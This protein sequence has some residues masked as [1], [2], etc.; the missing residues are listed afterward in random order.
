V[1]SRLNQRHAFSTG[2]VATSILF[3]GCS[4]DLLASLGNAGAGAPTPLPGSATPLASPARATGGGSGNTGT[5]K[6]S[7]EAHSQ[8]Q[9]TQTSL[10]VDPRDDKTVYV[11]VEQDGFFKTVDGGASWKR[12]VTGIGGRERQSGTG[13]CYSEFYSTVV[14]PRNSQHVC[15]ALAAGPG[16]LSMMQSDKEGV[17]CSA[18][19]GATWQQRVTASMNTAIYAVAIDPTDS[20]VLYAGANGN[21][22]SFSGADPDKLFNSIGVVYKSTDGG[23]SW[24]ELDT[25]FVKGMRL[26]DLEIAASNPRLLYGAAFVLPHN[27]GS[28]GAATTQVSLLR[29]KD[30]GATW[31]SKANGLDSGRP[32]YLAL[33]RIALSQRNPDRLYATALDTRSYWT[34]DGG[35]LFQRPAFSPY[36][37]AFSF[38]PNDPEGDRLLGAEQFGHGAYK[39]EDGGANWSKIADMPA[40]VQALGIQISDLE[41]SS[42][43]SAVAYLSGTH[44]RVYKTTDGGATWTKVLSGDALPQ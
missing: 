36:M 33:V 35:E 12:I 26:A 11:G 30:G 25:S 8:P 29:T 1:L 21:P 28:T 17:Y 39:S 44:G 38:D 24:T 27:G 9:R 32:G 7:C 2:V 42:Q 23:I 13:L 20:N 6:V 43:T 14:D 10:A 34:A 41:F 37:T 31:E 4:A 5:L 15:T 16:T 40:E 18:D 22:A 19:G 3:G